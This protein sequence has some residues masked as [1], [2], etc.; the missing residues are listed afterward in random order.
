MKDHPWPA[1]DSDHLPAYNAQ[2][3]RSELLPERACLVSTL[4][5]CRLHS[6]MLFGHPDRLGALGLTLQGLG[7]SI[8]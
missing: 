1:G 7:L 4:G 3:D 8:P 2:A 5:R 6:P